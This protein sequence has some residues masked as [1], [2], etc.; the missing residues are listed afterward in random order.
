MTD[1]L[2]LQ[3]VEHNR[4]VTDDTLKYDAQVVNANGPKAGRALPEPETS[5]YTGLAEAA[6]GALVI[7]CEYTGTCLSAAACLA[8]VNKQSY[9]ACDA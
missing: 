5:S 8:T 4:Q 9:V 1:R 7:S 2:R 3:A 6:D